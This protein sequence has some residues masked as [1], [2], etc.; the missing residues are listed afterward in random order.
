MHVKDE[1][2]YLHIKKALNALYKCSFFYSEIN[3]DQAKQELDTSNYLLANNAC[4]DIVLGQKKFDKLHTILNRAF[5]F[6]LEQHKRFLPLII[7][8]L[9]AES[10]LREDNH[11][12]LDAYIWSE[13]KKLQLVCD[14]IES[15]EEQLSVLGAL[16]IEVQLKMLKEVGKNVSKYRKSII[17]LSEL[18]V[19]EDIA[20]LYKKTK[21]SLGVLRKDLLYNRNELMADRIH[22]NIKKA[23]FYAVGAAHLGGDQGIIAK[24][25]RKGIT[26]KPI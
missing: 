10:V 7:L 13:A 14:G 26:A 2:A 6:D 22:N 24:L 18:Y 8:N 4:L 9:L 5:G 11:E 16:D 3:L 25:K 12:A 19:N 1:K 17:H 20:K 15:L 23:S 21:M